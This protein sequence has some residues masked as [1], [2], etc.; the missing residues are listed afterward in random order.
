MHRVFKSTEIR[1]PCPG[2]FSADMAWKI[3]HA[4]ALF[5]QRSRHNIDES[6]RVANENAI[7]IGRDNRPT[8]EMIAAALSDGIRSAGAH[9]M[10]LGAVD[11][12]MVWFAANHLQAVGAVQVT[13]SGD[14]ASENGLKIAGPGARPITGASGLQDIRRIATL[15]RVGRTGLS[16]RYE[17]C[18]VRDAYSQRLRRTLR[19]SRGVRLLADA[20]EGVAAVMLHAVFAGIEGLAMTLMEEPPHADRTPDAGEHSLDALGTAVRAGGFDAGV[21]FDRDADRCALVAETGQT[22]PADAVLALLACNMLQEPACAGACIVH[23]VR[24]GTAA[25]RAM[26]RAGAVLCRQ[27]SGSA[28]IAA[29][30]AET[31]GLLGGDY[32]GRYCFRDSFFRESPATALALVLSIL[33]AEQRPLSALAAPYMP[34]ARI[35]NARIEVRDPE[36]SLRELG[37]AY[38]ASR[39]DYLD[40]L[41]ISD[42]RWR[43]TIRKGEGEAALYLD[44]EADDRQTLDEK[45]A[46]VVRTARQ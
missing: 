35:S 19:L 38:R 46:D 12:P 23:D 20:G 29:A 4:T 27:R 26:Q 42:A 11:T 3:G 43:C 45:F 8:S 25:L 16:G 34:A 2:V 39:I 1:G 40:G 32:R 15:L 36:A 31:G 14:P 41:T 5:L 7:V 18:D 13:A 37:R 6:R 33:S 17:R 9:V 22:I 10:D 30:L 44:M 28:H 24:C 21:W